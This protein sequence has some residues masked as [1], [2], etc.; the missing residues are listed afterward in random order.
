MSLRNRASEIY[1]EEIAKIEPAATEVL[2]SSN[3]GS[4]RTYSARR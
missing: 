4:A 2:G 3:N 1:A